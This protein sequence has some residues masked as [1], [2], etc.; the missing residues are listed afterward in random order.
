MNS[1]FTRITV[2]IAFLSVGF[3]VN[4][5][6]ISSNLNNRPGVLT[7]VEE[8]FVVALN[9]G[10][11]AGTSVKLRITL[12]NPSQAADIQLSLQDPITSTYNNLI[13]D[14][15]G[16]SESTAAPFFTINLNAKV[17][18]T[19]A[20]VYNYSISVINANTNAVMANSNETV[21]VA[22]PTVAP[23]IFS[24]IAGDTLITGIQTP[25]S[26]STTTGTFGGT[27]VRVFFKMSPSQV[28]NGVT[29][30]YE[31]QISAWVPFTVNAN[32]EA[33]FGPSGGFPL[34][35]TSSQFRVTY[36]TPGVYDYKM[37]ILRA[38]DLTDT[39]AI[40]NEYVVVE[41]PTLP[42]IS[43]DLNGQT[44]LVNTQT[45]Y[46]ISTVA[47]DYLN[48]YVKVFFKAGD[49]AQVPN[50]AIE[51][52]ETSISSWLPLTLTANG[53]LDFGPALGFPLQNAST[54]F[55]VTFN[56]TGTYNYK[57]SL[58]AVSSG[59]TLATVNESVTVANAIPPTISS[60]L[61]GLTINT[62]TQTE[63]SITT[64]AND[65][66]NT[67]V[68]VFFKAGNAAQAANYD[69][70]YWE[71]TNSTWIPLTLT[72]NGE[73]DFGPALGFPL[74]NAS[75]DFRVTFDAAGVYAYKLSLYEV[76]TG[77]TLAV[78]NESVTVVDPTPV[79]PE[80]YSDLDGRT[81]V[82]VNEEES[83][84]V[85]TEKNDAPNTNVRIK[86]TLD[87]PS[88]A[89]FLAMSFNNPAT[90]AFEQLAFDASGV[91]FAGN[92]SGFALADADYD[93]KVT[94][95][96]GGTYGYS[97]ELVNATG[98]TVLADNDEQV[99]VTDNSSINENAAFISNAFPNPTNDI[100]TIQTKADGNGTLDVFNITGKKVMNQ[101]INGSTNTVSMET[102]PAG[103]YVFKISQGENTATVRVVKN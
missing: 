99:V 71:T 83:F 21:T 19:A 43:S 41:D 67:Y 22:A 28:A 50:Y 85:T 78:A 24:S 48:T 1:L 75:T 4:A 96:E 72:P 60:D 36:N 57:M 68:K 26:V 2:I 3:G 61:N 84:T 12:A 51:Y 90:S 10:A 88:Q 25:Y 42:T 77:D 64:V 52:W 89:N 74:Q 58:Y 98:G 16:I 46:A 31:P 86:I 20:G 76:A 91:A 27:M 34:A 82:L 69:I 101:T 54:D 73:L 38:S 59:D 92:A 45:E 40:A 80:I 33:M 6:T 56:A 47:N 53:E 103:V 49:V 66:L 30:Y 15:A 97:L 87:T 63:Y 7:N 102:L 11:Q 23:T 13:F 18:F 37:A 14:G 17:T 94:F 81:G 65:Y 32:G 70:E 55:R 9:A 29:E 39:L 100:I 8:D 5:Q 79:A 95:F 44:I 93:F 62:N 35:S